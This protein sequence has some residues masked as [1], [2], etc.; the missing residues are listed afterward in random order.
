MMEFKIDGVVCP[1]AAGDVYLPGYSAK[2]LRSVEAWREGSTLKLSVSATAEV[3]RLFGFALDL[4]RGVDFNDSYHHAE[5]IVD[6]V[7]VFEGRV[8]LLGVEHTAE[9]DSYNVEVRSGGD[10]WAES[11]ALKRLN[12]SSVACNRTMTM[13]GVRQSWSDEGAVRMLPVRRDSYP[14]PAPTGLFVSQQMLLP[15]DYVPFISVRDVIRSIMLDSGYTLRSDFLDTAFARRLMISGAY[16]RPNV[17]AAYAQMGFKAMR[18]VSTT[19]TAGVLGRVDMR[20][21]VMADSLGALVD[22]VNPN[23]EDEEGVPLGDAYSAGGCFRFELGEPTFVPRREINVAFDLHLRYTTDYRIV[24]SK[25]LK[26]FDR[27]YLGN[28]CYVDTVLQNP[29]KDMRNSIT[30]GVLYKLFIFDY[31][32]ELTYMLSGVG[33]IT[34]AV[35][36]VVFDAEFS[37]RPALY[38]KAATDE[39]FVPYLNDWALYEGYVKERGERTV[40]L[41]VRTPY[42]LCTP[43]SPRRFNDL[44]IEGAEQGQKITLHARCSITPVFSGAAGYGQ[45]LTFADMANHD[46]AQA[47]LLG[48]LAQMFNLCIYSHRPSRTLYIE[49]YDDFFSAEECDWRGRQVEESLTYD[50]CAVESF[51]CT[52]LGYQHPDGA[53]ARMVVGEGKELGMWSYVNNSY[54]A[55]HATDTRRNALFMPTA[56]FSGALSMAPSAEI[57]TVG[58]R[59]SVAE[60]DYIAPRIALYYGMQPLPEDEIWPEGEGDDYPLVAFHAPA[61]G[62]TLCYDDRDGCK[63]LHSYFDAEL[64]QEA[65]RQRLTVRVM[66]HP[67]EYISLFDPATEGATIRS[68]FRLAVGGDSSLFRLD[69]V[70]DYDAEHHIATCR[71][72]RLM[73]D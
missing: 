18:T 3:E 33:N 49:P 14:E 1:L 35:S 69:E 57:L 39:I 54:A 31:N 67:E 52:K 55:K 61:M 13:A 28:N 34:A 73:V 65:M 71:F 4:H 43:T 41:T 19:A 32:P 48:A 40:E 22:T 62:E 50:E 2:R 42:E 11:A 58:D 36:N 12:K 72:Q 60:G 17:E 5:L 30:A 45:E 16:H 23:V 8:V 38:F 64:Q 68:R 9:G 26:G 47:T 29:F 63:G 15:Q 70:V 66:L 6:G 7:V 44:S 24:S 20:N 21:P 51:E 56:S 46:I 59:D 25:R 10:D 53:A 27:V 37:G